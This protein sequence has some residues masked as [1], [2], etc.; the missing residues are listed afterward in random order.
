MVIGSIA[1]L[2]P[3]GVLQRSGGLCAG[4]LEDV[5]LRRDDPVICRCARSV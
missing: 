5:W 4:A 2:I 3:A 1:A